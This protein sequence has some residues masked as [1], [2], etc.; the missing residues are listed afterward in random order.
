MLPNRK[1]QSYLIEPSQRT[2]PLRGTFVRHGIT[3][4]DGAAFQRHPADESMECYAFGRL[5]ETRTE[6]LEEHLLICE[7]CRIR[8]DTTEQYIQAMARGSL[9]LRQQSAPGLLGGVNEWLASLP[10]TCDSRHRTR[11]PLE[12]R[13]W[14]RP[15]V[16]PP[17]TLKTILLAE[18]EQ[19]VRTFVLTVL[20]E[21]GYHVITGVDGQDALEKSRQFKETIDLLLS[22][23]NMPHMTGTEL[24]TQMQIER[25]VLPV[26]LMSGMGDELL[27]LNEGWQFLPKPFEPD[28]LRKKVQHL[29]QDGNHRAASAAG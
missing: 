20:Q 27:P 10:V 22:D 15:Q 28:M 24:A 13:E 19:H 17:P 7:G 18:D 29:L 3:G 1:E 12:S 16:L 6:L 2:I 9:L 11:P 25:A 8:L 5:E 4:E 26:L 14:R 21:S 23:V